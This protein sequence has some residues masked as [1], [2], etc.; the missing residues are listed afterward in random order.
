[1]P[2]LKKCHKPLLTLSALV[3]FLA[4]PA[5]ASAN[6][7]FV[8]GF[9]SQTAYTANDS[10]K[11]IKKVDAGASPHI[12]P[13]GASVAYMHEGPGHK[14][15]LKVAAVGGGAGKT[16]MTNF[17]ESF[18]LKWSPNSEFILALRG[19]ELGK[20]KLVLVTVATGA[21]K[22]LASGFFLGFSFDPEGKE[23]VFARSAQQTNFP[24]RTNVF[25]VSAAG[26][27]VTPLTSDN[28]SEY[29]LWGPTGKIVFVKLLEANKRKYAPKN[30]LFLMNEN[31]K[32]VKRL[33]HTK[34]GQ[35]LQGLVPTAWSANGK[36]LLA[37]FG[38]QDTTYAVGVN[39]QTGA[40]R[41]IIE[42]TEQGLVGT[43]LSPNGQTVYG[44]TGGFEG[45]N[46]QVVSVPWSGGKP[47]VLVNKA[48]QPTF[49]F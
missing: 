23:V 13:D 36:R 45:N 33:T 44:S 46:G 10:G 39:V 17:Q 2:P 26:G 43:A 37:Q 47:K 29:P 28:I 7:A 16:L 34:V 4:L 8:R 5:F 3:L 42:A 35:L 15:E 11:G 19:G 32:G 48:Q 27:K 22:V 30:E 9:A 49:S 38:G 21:Q 25:K 41:P 40:Q 12:S 31:G 14:P 1:M 6:I 18:E 24:P 20:R